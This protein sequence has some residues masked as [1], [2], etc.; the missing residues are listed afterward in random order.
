MINTQFTRR[1]V[2]R[3]VGA[4]LP[5]VLASST[6]A[7]TC[8]KAKGEPTIGISTLGFGNLTNAQLAEELSQHDI[9]VVQLF[10]NQSDSRYWRYNGRTDLS[11]LTA[12]QCSTIAGV[13]RS[14]GISLHSLGVY[15]NLIHPDEAERRANLRYFEGMMKIGADMGILMFVSEAGHYHPEGPAPRVAYHFQ[16]QIWEQMVA[17]GKQLAE[18]AE[19]YNATILLEPFFQGFLASSKRTRVFLEEIDST[20]IRALL[21]PA[22]LLEVDDLEEMFDQLTPWIDCLHAKDRKLHEE[23]GIPAGKG[24]LDYPKFAALAG[25]YTPD[26]PFILEYVGP[27]DYLHA[28]QHLRQAIS[29][30]T[31]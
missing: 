13:Y 25:R 6:Y 17:T 2:I 18:L 24:D 29:K 9:H 7:S 31:I 26:A 8:A 5:A 1:A 23:Q 28:R 16:E 15:T 27:D 11:S 10:F 30:I 4:A 21:D 20:R 14:A 19:Q 22:N 12:A 3:A